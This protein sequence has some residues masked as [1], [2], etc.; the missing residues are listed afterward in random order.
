[1]RCFVLVCTSPALVLQ[2]QKVDLNTVNYYVTQLICLVYFIR[3]QHNNRKNSLLPEKYCFIFPFLE[4]LAH[5]LVEI[6]CCRY[7]AFSL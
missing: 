1:M 7:A 3:W 5:Q 4:F 2:F 6:D